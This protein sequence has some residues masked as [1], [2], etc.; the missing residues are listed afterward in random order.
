MMVREVDD[1]RIGEPTDA[2]IRITANA[3]GGTGLH[4]YDGWT[5]PEPG[6]PSDSA[7]LTDEHDRLCDTLGGDLQT[8]IS[9]HIQTTSRQSRSNG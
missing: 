5:G 1:A 3:T 4:I 9:D 7:G 6:L 2:L 8:S